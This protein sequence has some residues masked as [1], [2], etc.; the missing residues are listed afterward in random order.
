MTGS[1]NVRGRGALLTLVV[2][3][4]L[5]ILPSERS[6]AAEDLFGTPEQDRAEI[7]TLCQRKTFGQDCSCV[8]SF[9]NEII[10]ESRKYL[11][12]V[13]REQ[14][15]KAGNYIIKYLM[16]SKSKSAVYRALGAYAYDKI[17]LN[18]VEIS[19]MCHFKPLIFAYVAGKAQ[20]FIRKL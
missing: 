10:D 12:L 5:S 18:S 7:V 11:L 3:A 14:P 19:I 1:V 6:A 9:S 2:I 4:L 15:E 17:T 13:L 8:E 20:P 16:L